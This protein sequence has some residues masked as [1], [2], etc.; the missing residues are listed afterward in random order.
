MLHQYADLTRYALQQRQL[1]L[2][3]GLPAVEPHGE[4]AYKMF[5]NMVQHGMDTR[6]ELGYDGAEPGSLD[7]NIRFR[8]PTHGHDLPSDVFALS[9]AIRPNH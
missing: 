8:L 3:R 4:F 1:A 7:E 5:S 6:D 2:G 9:I